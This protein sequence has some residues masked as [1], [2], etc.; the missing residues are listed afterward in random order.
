MQLIRHF[1]T[2]W[3]LGNKFMIKL[4]QENINRGLNA[5]VKI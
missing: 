5:S 2:T 1:S 4:K 3:S